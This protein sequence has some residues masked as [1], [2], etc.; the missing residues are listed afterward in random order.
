MSVRWT[1]PALADLDDIQDF[2]GRDSPATA[3][4]LVGEIFDRTERLLSTQ[5]RSGRRGRVDG[6]F[7]LVVT[8]TPYIVVYRVQSEVQ[9][10]A[11][12]HGARDWPDAFE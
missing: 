11:V 3:F 9:I 4:R 1:L 12:V 5:P 2:V 6:T 10:L 7:E 8:N